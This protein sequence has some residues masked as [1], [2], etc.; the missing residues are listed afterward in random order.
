MRLCSRSTL[1][2]HA[3][4]PALAALAGCT[5]VVPEALRGQVDRG[6]TYPQL[7]QDPE[8]YRGRLV[9]MGGEVVRVEPGQ[10]DLVLTLTERPLSPAD[11]SPLLGHESRGD[12]VVQVPGAARAA[13]REGDVLT[14]VGAVLGRQAAGGLP[15]VPRLESRSITVWSVA[16]PQPHSGALRW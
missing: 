10:R 15:A 4:L 16:R 11:E 3:L 12:L 13:F 6:L 9:L 8:A 7:S 14:V 1:I 2:A 5:S